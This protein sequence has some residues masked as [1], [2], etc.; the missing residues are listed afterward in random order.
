MKAIIIS[1][2]LSQL[3]G[4]GSRFFKVAFMVS[5][6]MKPHWWHLRSRLG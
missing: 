6:L 5:W 2:F 4:Y 3:G 1:N